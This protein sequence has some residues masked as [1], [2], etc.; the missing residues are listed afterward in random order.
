[1]LTKEK[2]TQITVTRNESEDIIT[3]PKDVKRVIKKCHK[4][5]Y[6]H[7]FDNLD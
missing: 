4:Q 5:S 7:T 2:N 6:G 3:Y 1:M